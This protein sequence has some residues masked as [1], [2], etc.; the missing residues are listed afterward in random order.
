[1][2]RNNRVE[3]E[4]FSEWRAA[5]R[6]LAA[7]T[8]ALTKAENEGDPARISQATAALRRARDVERVARQVWEAANK[9]AAPL[10]PLRGPMARLDAALA[11]M[12]EKMAQIEPTL[13]AESP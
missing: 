8:G 7:A 11:V 13:N 6:R 3:L 4:A 9:D 1:M 12:S 5:R 2:D 10:D